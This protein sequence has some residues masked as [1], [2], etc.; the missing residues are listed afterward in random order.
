[1]NRLFL[2]ILA[3]FAGL[4]TQVTT[5]QARMC[6]GAETE[7]GAA[8]TVRSPA[9]IA[10]TQAGSRSVQRIAVKA[11]SWPGAVSADLSRR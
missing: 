2:A 9:R 3:L 7:I 4:A 10:I 1:M 11:W 6:N 8:Q 5:A